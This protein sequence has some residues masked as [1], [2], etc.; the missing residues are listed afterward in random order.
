M[1]E[2]AFNKV[3]GKKLIFSWVVVRYKGKKLK[4]EVKSSSFLLSTYLLKKKLDLTR[5]NYLKAGG[6]C[7]KSNYLKAINHL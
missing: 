1:K 2:V 3:F 6:V 7:H 5:S 4:A